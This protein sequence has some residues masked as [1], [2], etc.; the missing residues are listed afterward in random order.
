LP[1]ILDTARKTCERGWRRKKK[2]GLPF[3]LSSLPLDPFALFLSGDKGNDRGGRRSFSSS[4]EGVAPFSSPAIVV[5]PPSTED[6]EEEASTVLV[7]LEGPPPPPLPPPPPSSSFS[8]S[9]LPPPAPNEA[10]RGEGPK[11]GGGGGRGATN[12]TTCPPLAPTQGNAMVP[13]YN[14]CNAMLMRAMAGPSPRSLSRP[15]CD[16]A[17]R[18]VAVGIAE[19]T[20]YGQE[21][22]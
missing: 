5:P 19:D 8:L 18:V 14:G 21:D 17:W 16:E 13:S 2:G 15:P 6:K 20:R 7:L 10:A 22:V 4:F 1:R 11:E 12:A 3:G 9:R